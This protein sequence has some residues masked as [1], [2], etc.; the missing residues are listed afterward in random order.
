[1]RDGIKKS[2]KKSCLSLAWKIKAVKRRF[3]L[4]ALNKR[5]KDVEESRDKWKQKANDRQAEIQKLDN[6]LSKLKKDYENLS[7]KKV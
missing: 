2:L 4:K 6:E 5:F 7:K 3:E 1:M